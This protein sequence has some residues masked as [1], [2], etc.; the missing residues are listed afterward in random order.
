VKVIKGFITGSLAALIIVLFIPVTYFV[1]A[2]VQS[3]IQAPVQNSPR[4][5]D[6]I[7]GRN[8]MRIKN[9]Y[10]TIVNWGS[11][12]MP[13]GN[14]VIPASIYYDG[15]QYISLQLIEYVFGDRM[16]WNADSRTITF[17]EFHRHY[18]DLIA[19]QT[20]LDA[21]GN[22]W[23]Y[24]VVDSNEQVVGGVHLLV[25]DPNRGYGRSYTLAGREAYE[26]TAAGIHFA[27]LY[28]PDWQAEEIILVLSTIEYGNDQNT[29]DGT[30]AAVFT[31]SNDRH[32][33]TTLGSTLID[34]GVLYYT[35]QYAHNFWP[36]GF[37]FFTVNAVNCANPSFNRLIFRE[38][39]F[40]LEL[41]GVQNGFLHYSVWRTIDG[42]PL[43]F[44]VRI[45]GLLSPERVN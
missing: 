41:R 13:A 6:W 42:E 7:D 38:G 32:G 29:Q 1:H 31:P 9:T 23:V 24:S 33:V 25:Q 43:N 20:R 12:I 15:E 27:R 37:S 16:Q 8:M 35:E 2:S 17:T 28:K 22:V 10:G 21:N 40:K 30:H 14:N 26:F 39:G 45:D 44:R 3:N 19:R 5:S 11:N 4:G 36:E 34:G 18:H